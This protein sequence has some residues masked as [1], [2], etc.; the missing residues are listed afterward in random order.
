M[1]RVFITVAALLIAAA[2]QAQEPTV[3]DLQKQLQEL[4]A[5]IAKL[6]A[7]QAALPVAAAPSGDLA[8]RLAKL[9]AKPSVPQWALDTKIKGDFRYRYE[10]VDRADAT[11]KDRQRVRLRVGA[12]GKVNDSVDYGIRLATGGSSAT[13]ANQDIDGGT[14]KEI[15]LDRYY[16]D[17]HP[18]MFKGAHLIMGKM[19]QPWVARTGLIWDGDLNPEGFALTYANTY[20]NGVKLIAN[21][22]SFVLKE[23][24]GDD[25]QLWAGQIAA[26][27][28]VGGVTVLTGVSDFYYQNAGDQG[29]GNGLT[30]GM[31]NTVGTE[32]HLVEGF[33]SVGTKIGD[34][35]VAFNGQYVMNV[36]AESSDASA[37]LLGVKFGKA[38][39]KGEWEAG[40]N[41]RDTGADAV[42]DGFNDSDFAYGSTAS[43]GHAFW[44][45]YQIAKNLQGGATYLM[46]VDNNGDD[47]NTMQ[48]DLNFKF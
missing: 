42:P 6:E 16:V 19:A 9:E 15:M 35:P 18:E 34:L 12:Y 23:D 21:A 45:K 33:G 24:K 29:A 37:Y 38:K 40:Y 26:E 48:L 11:Y 7:Q 32:F 41:Y 27:T 39:A 25:L 28:K 5:K 3:A 30:S 46:A 22:G 2:A 13:S 36:A 10:N 44:A 1:K 8:A 14:K 17:L 43:H 31:N 4:S 20:S 47:V